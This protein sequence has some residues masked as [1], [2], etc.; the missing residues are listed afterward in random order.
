MIVIDRHVPQNSPNTMTNLTAESTM[1]L[2]E[3][4]KRQT[5]SKNVYSGLYF[6]GCLS[7]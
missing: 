2:L 3:G 4:I 1:D 5:Q 7:T 6:E